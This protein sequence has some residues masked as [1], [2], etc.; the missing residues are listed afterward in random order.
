MK[1]PQ[2]AYHHGDLRSSLVEEAVRVIERE[3]LDAFSLREVAR[4]VGVSPNAAYR[5]FED[6]D[7]LLSAVAAHGL[8]VLSRRMR[9]AIEAVSV[10]GAGPRAIAN[11]RATGR[12]YVAFALAKPELFRVTFGRQASPPGPD[13]TCTNG[14]PDPYRVLEGCL[15]ALVEASVISPERRAGAE[16]FAWT[17]V[18]GYAS[19][20]LG[21]GPLASLEPL[22]PVL[23]LVIDGVLGPSATSARKP[24]AKR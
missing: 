2:D 5:H 10:R 13:Q 16:L 17:T 15:D 21:G 12:A 4:R 7:A 23:D 18:H 8:G 11:L 24:A 6:K 20:A 14:E 9:E 3:G 1:K 19:L 22:E